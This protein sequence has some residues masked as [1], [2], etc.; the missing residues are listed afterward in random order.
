MATWLQMATI[1]VGWLMG[2][3][4]GYLVGLRRGGR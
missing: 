4:V 2:F 3:S 1:G